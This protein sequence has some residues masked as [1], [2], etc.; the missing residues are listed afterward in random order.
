MKILPFEIS[1][2]RL[3]WRDA[4]LL[5]QFEEVKRD[6]ERRLS[7]TAP[8]QDVRRGFGSVFA[9]GRL[10]NVIGTLGSW[11]WRN[12]SPEHFPAWLDADLFFD[13]PLGALPNDS[14]GKRFASAAA[15][16]EAMNAVFDPQDG[17]FVA[18]PL[19]V[20]PATSER[21]VG[22]Y[23]GDEADVIAMDLMIGVSNPKVVDRMVWDEHQGDLDKLRR[24]F[25]IPLLRVDIWHR[26]ERLNAARAMFD[27]NLPTLKAPGPA[28]LKRRLTI[29]ESELYIEKFGVPLPT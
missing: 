20:V 24:L 27:V 7:T 18:R 3:P 29:A 26:V 4:E 16:A 17:Q 21:P 25:Y 23:P 22:I 13:D 8:V 6:A 15:F 1:S 11:N 5:R 14:L 19:E 10:R 2:Q 28:S 12:A 9:I